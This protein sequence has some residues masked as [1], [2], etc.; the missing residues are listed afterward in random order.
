MRILSQKEDFADTLSNAGTPL[1]SVAVVV[2]S[3]TAPDN[4]FDL[5]LEEKEWIEMSSLK[6]VF[7]SGRQK[8]P[9]VPSHWPSFTSQW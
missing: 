2:S 9:V 5:R 8:R 6:A 7:D 4:F 1:E 3:P